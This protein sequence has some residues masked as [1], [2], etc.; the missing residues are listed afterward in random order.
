MCR[1]GLLDIGFVLDFNVEN[2]L[3]AIWM[4]NINQ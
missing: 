1:I 3:F 4:Y 2:I